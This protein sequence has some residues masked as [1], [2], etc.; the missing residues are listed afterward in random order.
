MDRV[1]ICGAILV[2]FSTYWRR[3]T[4]IT[5]GRRAPA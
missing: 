2:M 5:G 3:V 1:R 4:R